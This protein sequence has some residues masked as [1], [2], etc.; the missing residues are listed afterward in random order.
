VHFQFL[1]LFTNLIG[2]AI[3]YQ[4]ENVQPHIKVSSRFEKRENIHVNGSL[5]FAQ[6]LVISITDN[7]IGF[8]PTYSQKI[9]ELFSRLHARNQYPGTGIG[10]T[11][12]KKIIHNH[13]GF[14]TA[15]SSE[16]N[17][18]TFHVYIPETKILL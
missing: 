13:E 10:L 6:Y 8:D 9:F 3:K 17:G 5:P 4:Q 18:S 2:N 12:C 16:G 15:E 11:I 1:Q 7:G 14:I